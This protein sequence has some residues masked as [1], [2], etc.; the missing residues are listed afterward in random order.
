M[1][2]T[3]QLFMVSTYVAEPESYTYPIELLCQL[4]REGKADRHQKSG[5]H[6]MI[7]EETVKNQK[8]IPTPLVALVFEL[9]NEEPYFWQSTA[10]D[11]DGYRSKDFM[12]VSSK[13]HCPSGDNIYYGVYEK[14]W[15]VEL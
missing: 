15:I 7:F 4:D 11:Y 13:I 12:F 6:K 2:F 5:L 1:L 14:K 3:N 8:T 9:P 10:K